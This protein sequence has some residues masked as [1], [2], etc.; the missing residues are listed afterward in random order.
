M[1]RKTDTKAPE[2]WT[3]LHNSPKW[4]YFRDGRSLCGR[5]MLLKIPELEAGNEDSSS[6]CMGCR[7][8]LEAE[9]KRQAAAESRKI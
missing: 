2:G 9:L 7:R 6:N 8:K 1:K 4:H 3:Y 5:F